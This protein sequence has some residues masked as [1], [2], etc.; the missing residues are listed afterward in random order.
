MDY[1]AQSTRDNETI[2]G[3]LIR[4]KTEPSRNSQFKLSTQPSHGMYELDSPLRQDGK[5][6]WSAPSFAII[7]STLTRYMLAMRSEENE[8]AE[9]ARSPRARQLLFKRRGAMSS[10][11]VTKFVYP[12]MKR[13]L[14]RL[15]HTKTVYDPCLASRE[16]AWQVVSRRVRDLHSERGPQWKITFSEGPA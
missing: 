14:R 16:P 3:A 9:M 12:G 13:A 2:S 6:L 8:N 4:T 5:D 10:M 1:K 7:S 15:F 11:E